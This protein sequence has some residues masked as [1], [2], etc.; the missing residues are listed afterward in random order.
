MF[1][2]RERMLDSL[3]GAGFDATTALFALGVLCNYVLGFSGAQAGVA[4]IELP[5]RIRELPAEEFPRLTE[6]ADS[7]AAHLADEAF[8]YGLGLLLRGL[9]ADLTAT[10]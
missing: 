1:R 5:D 8:E 10:A 7:Y 6:V 4:P 2:L 3:R 9:V